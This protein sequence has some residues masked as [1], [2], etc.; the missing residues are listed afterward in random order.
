MKTQSD[1][2]HYASKADYLNRVPSVKGEA[3]DKAK[4]LAKDQLEKS[5][6]SVSKISKEKSAIGEDLEK[7]KEAPKE[8]GKAVTDKVK[9]GASAGKHLLS[10]AVS[11]V[12]NGL[13]VNPLSSLPIPSISTS[14]TV[15][16]TSAPKVVAQNKLINKPGIFFVKGFSVNPFKADDVGLGAMASNIP[17][18]KLYSWDNGDEIIKAINSRDPAQPIILVGHGMGSDTIVDVAN[19]LNSDEHS[20]RKIDLLVTMD[21]VGTE[22]DIIPQNVTENFN[23]IS[24]GDYLFN[25]GPNVARKNSATAVTNELRA[26]SH[27]EMELSQ[28]VQ[29]LVYEKINKSLMG[30]IE[31]RDLKKNLR[32]QMEILNLFKLASPTSKQKIQKLISNK[33]L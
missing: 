33:S 27:N 23:V 16:K 4:G 32:E 24:D 6:S 12:A 1:V 17:S 19:R 5:A 28:E 15:S 30:A 13:G 22:N 21:S 18:S 3:I 9:E 26:E 8:V 14:K 29:F 2:I 11:S 7:I 10:Q 31:K 25:D 20:F